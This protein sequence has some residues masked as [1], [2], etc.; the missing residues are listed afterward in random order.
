[1]TNFLHTFTP[2]PILIS[3][4]PITIYW[5]G[6]FV[7]SGILA[8]MFIALKLADYYG[9]N[10][11]AVIDIAFWTII[12][13]VIGARIYHVGLEFS[14]YW[15]NPLA[16]F[17]VWE[18]GL[19]I[20]GALLFGGLTAWYLVKK[21]NI[22]FWQ[23]AAIFAPGIALG[24]AIGRWGN[25]FNQELYGLPTNLSWGIP[26]APQNRLL[27]YYNYQYFH[28]T[29]LYESLGNFLIFLTLILIH[30]WIIKNPDSKSK[31]YQMRFELCVMSYAILYSLLRFSLEFIRIDP[32]PIIFGLRLPQIASLL[33]IFI[34][35]FA[36]FLIK[37]Q[38]KKTLAK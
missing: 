30:V 25:Y 15:S 3:I 11:T 36:Y 2:D 33:I 8:A 20:H 6:L 1:M 37:K 18:G 21:N 26:I 17:K 35:I 28:P 38:W 34:T 7:V 27:E 13:G 22:N 4:G 14:Y 19:A 9:I 29:F 10:K 31:I 12:F 5:Y 23:F 32:T 24:Q 16:I